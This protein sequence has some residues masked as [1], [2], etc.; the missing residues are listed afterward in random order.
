MQTKVRKKIRDE[1]IGVKIAN[2]VFTIS[3]KL[4]LTKNRE[5]QKET[6]RTAT[7]NKS[8]NTAEIKSRTKIGL[9]KRICITHTKHER[10]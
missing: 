2:T 8:R 10:K 3:I 7:K 6:I 9:S 4:Q 1:N 5:L